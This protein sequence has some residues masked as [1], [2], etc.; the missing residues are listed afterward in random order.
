[1]AQIFLKQQGQPTPDF[2]ASG[3]LIVVEGLSVDCDELQKDTPQVIEV[4]SS[5]SGAMIG[6]NGA[7]LAQ[8]LIPARKYEE[9]ESVSEDGEEVEKERVALPIDHNAIEVTLWP[10]I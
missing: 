9:V 6:G 8:I 2:S 5:P 4:R 7:Y 1:M 10:S 3:H